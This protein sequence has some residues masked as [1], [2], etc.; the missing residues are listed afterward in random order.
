MLTPGAALVENR[1]WMALLRGLSCYLGLLSS[2]KPRVSQPEAGTEHDGG[3]SHRCSSLLIK[4][5][6][7]LTYTGIKHVNPGANKIEA[8]RRRV[9]HTIPSAVEL[10]E[11][12]LH[13]KCK[14]TYFGCR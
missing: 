13:F 9:Y 10:A 8:A 11:T 1:Y 7:L 4:D 3:L 2:T 5:L 14:Y 6:P 12:T